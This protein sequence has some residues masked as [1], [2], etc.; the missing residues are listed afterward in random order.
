LADE[1][2]RAAIALAAAFA[3]EDL[4]LTEIPVKR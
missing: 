3:Q 1:D 2:V 4:P